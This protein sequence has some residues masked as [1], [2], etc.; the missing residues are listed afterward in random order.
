[1]KYL[2]QQGD[3]WTLKGSVV[4]GYSLADFHYIKKGK[5]I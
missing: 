3:G 5:T 4:Y 1:M 2:S